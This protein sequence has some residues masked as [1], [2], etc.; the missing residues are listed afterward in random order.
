[1][2]DGTFSAIAGIGNIKI[3]SSTDLSKVLH[4]PNLY[5]NLASVSKL[6][7]ELQCCAKFYPSYCIFQDLASGKTI[8]SAREEDG[9]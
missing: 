4:V 8:G 7:K 1:M 5:C 9:L 2:A 3:S 6:N